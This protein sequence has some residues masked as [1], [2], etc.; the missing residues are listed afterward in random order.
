MMPKCM[1]RADLVLSHFFFEKNWVFFDKKNKFF[2]FFIN[3]LRFK[4][5]VCHSIDQRK[6]FDTCSSVP[7]GGV[8]T[9]QENR[10]NM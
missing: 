7:P 4:I 2:C 3:F 1:I 8:L 6:I 5:F 10:S 9:G